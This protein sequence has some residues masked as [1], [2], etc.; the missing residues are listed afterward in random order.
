[1]DSAELHNSLSN[2]NHHPQQITH[3]QH[4]QPRHDTSPKAGKS[5]TA[6]ITAAVTS[7]PRSAHYHEPRPTQPRRQQH[8]RP[9][10][11]AEPLTV[12]TMTVNEPARTT[13]ANETMKS[14]TNE[15][16]ISL[17]VTVP[18]SP[19]D[20]PLHIAPTMGLLSG[21]PATST[22][23]LGKGDEW[24]QLERGDPFDCYLRDK[25]KRGQKKGRFLDFV[26]GQWSRTVRSRG[27]QIRVFILSR[28]EGGM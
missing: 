10:P 11:T 9:T 15:E 18:N 4:V 14:W 24:A 21:A 2:G 19:D 5:S 23:I 20:D 13:T 3:Q 17:G 25:Y 22:P 27:G 6:A 7:T 26:G 28:S 12:R 16:P 1:M 8:H